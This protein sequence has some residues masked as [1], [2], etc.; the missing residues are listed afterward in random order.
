LLRF[1]FLRLRARTTIT[2]IRVS[3]TRS[4]HL[5]VAIGAVGRRRFRNPC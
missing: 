1:V 5:A 4:T 3:R 2:T